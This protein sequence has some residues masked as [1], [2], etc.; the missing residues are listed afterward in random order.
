M[1]LRTIQALVFMLVLSVFAADFSVGC[2][3]GY[4]YGPVTQKYRSGGDSETWNI[5]VDGTPYTVPLEF[6][7]RVNLGD[8]VKFTGNQWQIVKTAS[9]ATPTNP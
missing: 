7:N 4:V 8:T 9:G 1:K 6:Y 2:G 5:A 3:S